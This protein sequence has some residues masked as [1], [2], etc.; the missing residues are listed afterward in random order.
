VAGDFSVDDLALVGNPENTLG[1][2]IHVTADEELAVNVSI[3]DSSFNGF[4]TPGAGGAVMIE[5]ATGN[6]TV[7]RSSFQNNSGTRGGAVEVAELGGNVLVED[8]LFARNEATSGTGGAMN[9]ESGGDGPSFQVDGSIT[10]SN[11]RFLENTASSYGGAV[12]IFFGAGG[13]YVTNSTF[14]DNLSDSEGGAIQLEDLAGAFT[15]TGSMFDGNESPYGGAIQIY[16]AYLDS[17]DDEE[18]TILTSTFTGNRATEGAGIRMSLNEV[19]DV[20]TR[21]GLIHSSTFFGN[22]I[23]GDNEGNN[24]G[25]SVSANVDDGSLAIVNSTFDERAAQ[26]ED[27]TFAIA[28][29]QEGSTSS[30]IS[31]STIV[32]PGG[33]V[34]DVDSEGSSGTLALS[35]VIIQSTSNE[36]AIG[37]TDAPESGGT[38]SLQ[39]SALSTGIG[40]F[41][42]NGAGNQL[43]VADLKLGELQDNG[44]PT[45]TRAPEETSPAINTGN[46]SV[47]GEPEFD[48]RRDG[49]D[50]VVQTIDIGAV[51]FQSEILPATGAIVN[52]W[53][54]ISA[55]AL[56]VLGIGSFVF[57]ALKKRRLSKND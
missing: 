36:P 34:M 12:R 10:F 5:D 6:F 54:P 32:G 43:S 40:S 47:S 27:P 57:V 14:T 29:S 19:E 52:P 28:I 23:E 20:N 26:G 21:L 53:L 17:T 11:T 42:S 56:L 50:R 49:F 18:V 7:T 33:V 15:V 24:L 46:E 25:I 35:H 16:D 38:A 22:V 4:L 31:H 1:R 48:Q 44:G 9:F 3:T 8:S 41:V 45:L 39:Y 13:V 30:S 55:A 37:R 2:A 51:E